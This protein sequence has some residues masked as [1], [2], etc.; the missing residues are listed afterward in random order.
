[1]K[2]SQEQLRQKLTE[3]RKLPTETEWLEFKKAEND[4]SFDK[5]GRYFSAL[6]NEAHLQ[7]VEYGWLI[8]GVENTKKDII[9][10]S[11]RKNTSLEDLKHKIASNTTGNIS[12]IAIYE[13]SLPEGRV[14]MFQI[15]PAPKGIPIAWNGHYYGRDGE[16]LVALNLQEMETIRGIMHDWS[17]E[18]CEIATLEDLDSKAIDFACGEFIRKNPS[19]EDE[20]EK[21]DNK[22]FLNKAKFTIKGQITKASVLLLGKSESTHLLSPYLARITWIVKDERNQE[23]DYE[24]VDPPFILASVR[25][26]EKIRNLKYRYMPD[27]TLFPE[28]LTKYDPWVMREALH[29]CI[30]HQDYTLKG[31]ITVVEKPD[32]L[33]F[34]NM[35]SF[36]PGS[37]E[38][39]IKEDAPPKQYRN[40]FLVGAMANVNMIDTIGSGIKRMF[41][42]QRDRFFPMP[43]YELSP[44]EVTVR[45]LGKILNP[46]F[47]KVLRE[48]PNLD[49]DSVIL[50]DHVQKGIKVPKEAY[51]ILKLK[52]LVE[53]RYPNIYLSSKVHSY[54]GKKAE[55]I[56]TRGLDKGYYE[57]LIIEYIQKFGSASRKDIDGLLMDKLPNIFTE[58]QKKQKISNL[59]YELAK[60]KNLI[61]NQSISKKCPAWVLKKG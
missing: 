27:M 43:T 47:T 40:P 5:L 60:K 55:Y 4:Y 29:N 53:G 16:S 50:L 3:F 49:L 34:S 19:L 44:N 38:N 36:L 46:L 6:S 21:W 1:M 54:L 25:L 24:H 12:F 11:Y 61:E 14:I 51:K 41:I 42:K 58:N 18:I 13:L 23:L 7:G 9:G 30:A 59:L 45:I 37:V 20:I 48:S 28:E 22:T 15:P 32:E 39:V 17:Q 2:Y 56:K 26:Q 52:G 8:F 10:T 57:K 35:G 31:K 33:I